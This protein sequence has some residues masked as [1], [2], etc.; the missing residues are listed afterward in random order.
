MAL[1]DNHF[2]NTNC[3]IQNLTTIVSGQEYALEVTATDYGT[4]TVE[5]KQWAVYDL[6]SNT[7]VP[8]SISWQYV[9]VS[10]TE[11]LNATGISMYP[12]PVK[13]N[14]HVE[15]G[16]ESTV[17]IL[18]TNGT[19]MYMKDHVL[20]EIIDMSGFAPGVYIIRIENN[21]QITQHKIIVE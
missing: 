10:A 17:R 6:A 13:G 11:S 4:V 7:N 16:N 12:N 5:L 3:E 20:N 14:L 2:T 9:E 18:N 8:S 15:L 1:D 21:D 19:V